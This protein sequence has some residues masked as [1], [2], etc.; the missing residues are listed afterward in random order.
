MEE[1]HREERHREERTRIKSKTSCYQESVEIVW[2]S[3]KSPD[4]P[5]SRQ[6]HLTQML[7][8]DN[9]GDRSGISLTPCIVFCNCTASR[10]VLYSAIAQLSF[11]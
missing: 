10:L 8:F 6:R 2:L 3:K 7:D 11:D 4:M 5:Y 1:R 9:S